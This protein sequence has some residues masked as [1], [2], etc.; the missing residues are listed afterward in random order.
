MFKVFFFDSGVLKIA[1]TEVDINR[2]ILLLLWMV[3]YFSVLSAVPKHL[4][5]S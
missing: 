3:V 5:T 4:D 2:T 1:W